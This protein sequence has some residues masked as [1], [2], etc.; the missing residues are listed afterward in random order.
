[1]WIGRPLSHATGADWVHRGQAFTPLRCTNS[2]PDMAITGPLA[3]EPGH[4]P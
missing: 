3:D 4:H 1:M 2:V